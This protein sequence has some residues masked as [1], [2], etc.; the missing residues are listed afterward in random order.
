MWREAFILGPIVKGAKG[1]D[2]V[3]KKVEV[4]FQRLLSSR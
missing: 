4:A 3:D 1:V 2:A